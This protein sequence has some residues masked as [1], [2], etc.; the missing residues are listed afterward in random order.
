MKMP[1]ALVA[2]LF[3]LTCVLFAYSYRASEAEDAEPPMPALLD[4][5]AFLADLGAAAA[6]GMA[7][8]AVVA[9]ASGLKGKRAKTAYKMA[10]KLGVAFPA[11][12]LDPEA[13]PYNANSDAVRL[14]LLIEA[15][16]GEDAGVV[17]ALRGGYGASRLLPK[18][19][20][21][22]P[23]PFPKPFV[24][25]SDMTFLHLFLRRWGWP[26]IHGAMFS[27]LP[28]ADKDEDNFRRLAALL[29]GKAEELRYAG[30]KPLNRAARERREPLAAPITGGN[31]TCVAAAVG[32][33]WPLDP[34]G[35]IV[36]L[37]D[38][39]EKG[40]KLDRMFTQLDQAGVF[41]AA[42]AVLLGS[43]TEGDEHAAYALGRFA[44][45]CAKPVFRTDLFG[46]GPKN[47][48]L[49][50]NVPA[51]LA[52]DGEEGGEAAF[53]LTI[54]VDAGWFAKKTE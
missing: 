50:F 23:P 38:V 28:Q 8:I 11:A 35:K 49:V 3:V 53:T 5:A 46:H 54:P 29:A 30:I 31:L 27:E 10:G 44:D 7:G 22:A 2:T 47:Y 37:E 32:T 6:G 18:L 45:A 48:P 9:P 14:D 41:D 21:L 13:A 43:F 19:D 26:T 34:A 20:K 4:D 17:W 24:G 15:L 52:P 33:P 16:A 42:E 39:G 40:Y 12:A 36:F 1:L 51:V 25:Y